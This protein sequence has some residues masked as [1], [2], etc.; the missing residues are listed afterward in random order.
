[1]PKYLLNTGLDYPPNRRAE[2]GDIVDDLPAKSIKWL[3]EQ[4]IIEAYDASAKAAVD[5]EPEVEVV[6]VEEPTPE[7]TLDAKETE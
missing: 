2:A 6:V 1:M 4:G 5:V 3:R 7:P